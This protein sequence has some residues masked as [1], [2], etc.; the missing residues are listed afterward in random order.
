MIIVLIILLTI[1]S[2]SL[3]ISMA[4]VELSYQ[5]GK[6]VNDI[7]RKGEKSLLE[8]NE[9]MNKLGD[10]SNSAIKFSMRTAKRGAKLVL[11]LLKLVVVS[12]RNLLCTVL[13]LVVIIDIIVFLLLVAVVGAY[14][15]L[16][17]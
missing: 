5:V 8:D 9:T 17:E 7:R 13:G 1:I 12:L 10:V 2:I 16:F 14:L 11:R 3:S 15:F 6:R 4:G